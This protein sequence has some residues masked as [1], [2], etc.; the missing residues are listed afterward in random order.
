MKINIL[1]KLEN[2]QIQTLEKMEKKRQ[3]DYRNK[4]LV[5][6]MTEN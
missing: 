4:K 3:K 5:I 6:K 2:L 1:R